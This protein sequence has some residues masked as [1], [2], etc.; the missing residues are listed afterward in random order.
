[1]E[2]S[3]RPA[4]PDQPFG[5]WADDLAAAFVR[6][7]PRR[8]TEQSFAGTICKV[9]A[10]PLQIS[11]VRASGH[12]VLRLASHIASSTEDLCFVNLQLEG[13]GR[14]TQRGH[15]QLSAPGDLALADTTQPF[16]IAHR[17]DFK[18]FCFAVPRRLLPDG[19]FDRPRLALSAT[20][21]GRALS[22]TLASYAEL[23]LSGRQLARTSTMVGAHVAELIAHAPDLL[24]DLPAERVHTPVL[25]S[26]MLDHIDRHSH[27]PELG[28]PAL[29]RKF[30]CSE[31]YVHRL[32][33]GT[34]RSV[35]EHVNEK[36]I[37]MCARE[38][39]DRNSAHKTI[40][41][42]AFAAGFRDIS[43]FNRLF[44]RHNGL[45]PREF[46]RTAAG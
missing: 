27:A 30:R 37:T 15:E 22:R 10:A 34:G 12:T 5:S 2:W 36:R 3:T 18:L 28:A 40:A 20:E 29:A 39:L 41:E 9:D 4:R 14:T 16:E 13:L 21:A 23:C 31:R 26:M 19:L 7:E 42:I 1:M 24:T 11:L 38:L 43:H 45:A 32:F 6:L 8:I 17:H 46:R 35:G 33:A 44:K 25:L